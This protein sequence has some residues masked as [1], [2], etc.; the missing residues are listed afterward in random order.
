[1]PTA[2]WPGE[3]LGVGGRTRSVAPANTDGSNV[4]VGGNKTVDILGSKVLEVFEADPTVLEGFGVGGV[5]LWDFRP[6]HD[7][8][9]LPKV[10]IYASSVGETIVPNRRSATEVELFFGVRFDLSESGPRNAWAPGIASMVSTLQRLLRGPLL[11]EPTIFVGDECV[12]LAISSKPGSTLFLVDPARDSSRAA[13]T[14]QFSHVWKV[15]DDNLT[16]VPTDL[17]RVLP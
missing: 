13:G 12:R 11:A 9:S 3:V 14:M 5:E 4:D 15:T 1:M 8:S 2:R 7:F 6:F 17:A 10:Q 16:G